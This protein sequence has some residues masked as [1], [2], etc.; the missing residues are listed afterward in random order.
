MIAVKGKKVVCALNGRVDRK[1]KISKEIK[2]FKMTKGIKETKKV[3][4][5][6]QIKE[7]K[8]QAAKA[9]KHQ[10]DDAPQYIDV[11]NFDRSSKVKYYTLDQ[12]LPSESIIPHSDDESVSLKINVIDNGFRTPAMITD[13]KNGTFKIVDGGAR[14]K[15]ALELGYKELPCILMSEMTDVELREYA[16]TAAVAHRHLSTPQKALMAVYLEAIES[17]LAKQRKGAGGKK[18]KAL[19]EKAAMIANMPSVVDSDMATQGEEPVR[20]GT[21]TVLVSNIAATEQGRAIAIAAKKCGISLDTAQKALR[22]YKKFPER[23][24]EAAEKNKPILKVYEEI[25][26][27]KTKNTLGQ[28]DNHKESIG[29]ETVSIHK[30]DIDAPTPTD[31]QAADENASVDSETRI[32]PAPL[33]T[34]E[35]ENNSIVEDIPETPTP[36]LGDITNENTADRKSGEKPRTVSYIKI[37]TISMSIKKAK[38]SIKDLIDQA[39]QLENLSSIREIDRD[40]IIEDLK[41]F[42]DYTNSE[43][44]SKLKKVIERLSASKLAA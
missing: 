14:Y 31:D 5:F 12:L 35:N 8:V 3:T 13:N 42:N 43:I 11:K 34:I 36:I 21:E 25:F 29:E 23:L 4:N 15:I 17:K 1:Y 19:K 41:E 26:G 28:V 37:E 20:T 18:L 40:R 27:D 24:I 2:E 30:K 32:R 10:K 33:S 6:E 16:L 39:V 9:G 38:K 7:P 22:I 44:N